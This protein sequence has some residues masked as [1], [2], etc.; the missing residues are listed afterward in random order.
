MDGRTTKQ[1]LAEGMTARGIRAAV[2]DGSLVRVRR[3]LYLA[4][5][6]PGTP[7]HRRLLAAALPLLQD[8]VVSHQ[9]AAVLHGLHLPDGP[10]ECLHVIQPRR[11]RGGGQRRGIMHS[12]VVRLQPADVVLVDGVRVTSRSRT[13]VDLARSLPF[14]DAVI[15]MDAALHDSRHPGRE[16]VAERAALEAAVTRAGRV[17]GIAQARAVLAVADGR[18]ESP[19]E[20]RSRLLMWREQLPTPEIQYVVLDALG[21]VLARLDFAWPEQQVYGECDGIVKYTTLLKPGQGSRDVLIREKQRDND[22]ADLGWRQVR[23]LDRDLQRP[24]VLTRRIRK[25]LSSGNGA[26]VPDKSNR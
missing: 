23:W 19:L 6:Q 18:A 1:L 16:N 17:A 9:S 10:G 2:S 4:Q 25:A 21:H 3:G 20:T 26:T 14:D 13:V 7:E 24:T 12:H 11:T 22:L 8:A 15:V 5:E